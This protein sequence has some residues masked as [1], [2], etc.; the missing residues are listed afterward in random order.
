MLRGIFSI[1]IIAAIVTSC[2][3]SGTKEI[4]SKSGLSE[5]TTKVEFDSLS[6]NPDKY[7]GKNIIVEG[8]VVHVCVN[9][10]KKLF[11]TGNNPDVM[12]FIAAGE[13]MP[14]FPMELLGSE[15]IVEGLITK[16]GGPDSPAVENCE[17]EKTLSEQPALANVIMEYKSHTVK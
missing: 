3:N 7:V 11:I 17:T 5:S 6:A 16:I 10:G 9:S 12:L 2:G 4:S 15:V 1:L 8:K 13:N 14:K